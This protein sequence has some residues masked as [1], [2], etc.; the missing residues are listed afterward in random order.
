MSAGHC[1]VCGVFLDDLERATAPF[2]TC[3]GCSDPGAAQNDS[4]EEIH[5]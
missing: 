1:S 5:E 3:F 2:D 4:K